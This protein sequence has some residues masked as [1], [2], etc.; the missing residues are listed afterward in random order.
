MRRETLPLDGAVS[1]IWDGDHEG[2]L[3]PV[4]SFLSDDGEHPRPSALSLLTARQREVVQLVALG[5]T[6]IEIA[7]RLRIGRRTVESHLER[8]RNR[9]GLGS[10]TELAAW[11]IRAGMGA[12]VPTAR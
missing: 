7:G 3:G 6:N 1:F 5:L 2:L 11:S 12:G 8:A 10:R 4:L 9:L